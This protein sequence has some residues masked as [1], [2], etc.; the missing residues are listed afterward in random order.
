MKCLQL[1]INE[2]VDSFGFLSEI[3]ERQHNSLP[4]DVGSYAWNIW[5]KAVYDARTNSGWEMYRRG[6]I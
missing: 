1:Y 4:K 2:N 6:T 5:A 3:C